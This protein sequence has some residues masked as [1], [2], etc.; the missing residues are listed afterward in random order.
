LQKRG[1]HF[2]ATA[3]TL[4]ISAYFIADL[5]SLYIESKL[6]PVRSGEQSSMVAGSSRKQLAEEDFSTIWRRNLFSS[7]GLLPGENATGT[8]GA[9]MGGAPQPTTLPLNLVGTLILRNELRSIATIEDKSA[10]MVYPVRIEDEIPSK[11]RVLQIEPRRVIFINLGSGRR[12]YVELPEDL[13]GAKVQ[14]GRFSSAP[15]AQI[16]RQGNNYSVPRMDIDRA[17]ADL[18]N[19]LTQARAVPHYD[20]GVPSGYKL[21]QVQPDGFFGKLGLKDQDIICGI[22]GQPV[23][24]PAKALELLGQLKTANHVELCVKRDGRQQNFAYDIR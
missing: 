6:P 5:A 15:A 12:E 22:D 3:L 7:K 11:I 14:L 8:G 10:S 2:Y 16:E 18:N 24:D 13:S 9:D 17:F 21:F 4:T 20:N 23:N 1:A 19:V